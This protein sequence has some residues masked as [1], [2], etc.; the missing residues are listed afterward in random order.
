MKYYLLTFNEDYAD[1]HNVPGVACF[2]EK[3][4]KEWLT[5]P[6]GKLN[7][8]FEEQKAAHEVQRKKYEDFTKELKERKLYNTPIANFP[9]A[10]KIWY[11][12]NKVDYVSQYSVPRRVT[13]YLRAHLG[14]GGDCFEESYQ[15]LYLMSEFVD[16]KIVDVTEVDKSFYDTFK[17]AG[18]S[19]LSLTNV[20]DIQSIKEHAE[21]HE[22]DEE[23]DNE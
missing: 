2:T 4:Y 11:E 17:K 15:H 16:A 21:W 12:R 7:P 6:S 8:K 22:E 10:D 23:D 19:S 3:E 18:L 1:E 9:S 5:T 20:F 14:N 13:S